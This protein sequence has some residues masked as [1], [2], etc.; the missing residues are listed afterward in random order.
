MV[1]KYPLMDPKV[2]FAFKQI[3]AGKADESRI[4]LIDLL[5]T[6]LALQGDNKISN[7]IYLNSYTDKEYQESKQSI[8]DIKVKTETGKMIDIEMQIRDADNY[9]KR[10][11]YYWSTMYK[12]QI[13][14]GEAY[15]E[16]KKCIVISIMNFDLIQENPHYHS[17]FRIVEKERGIE[18]LE[19]LE[20]TT[21]N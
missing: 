9:R 20:I 10:S 19:D 5:N 13:V 17:M 15:E 12:E 7:I 21:W 14:E 11:L 16:L 6:I 8:L 4:V 3:F 1:K 2:D 18:L